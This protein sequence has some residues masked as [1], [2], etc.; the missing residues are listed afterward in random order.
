MALDSAEPG[1]SGVPRTISSDGQ[2]EAL[3]R[4]HNMFPS[5][6]EI[7]HRQRMFEL[8][9]STVERQVMNNDV[10]TRLNLSFVVVP[11]GSHGLTVWDCSS[12]MDCLAIGTISPTVFF[13]L[14]AQKIHFPESQ[15]VKI[16]RKT[17]DASG[18]MLGLQ[19]GGVCFNLQYC[20][21]TKVT[22]CWPQALE[23]PSSHPAFDVPM[24]SLLKLN[25]VR[26]LHYLQHTITHLA[27]FRLA[28]RAIKTWAK[29]RGIYSSKFG[30]LGDMH[31][32]LLLAR[33][34]KTSFHEGY[35]T[36]ASEILQAYFKHYA[37]FDWQKEMIYDPTY[38]ADTTPSYHRSYREPLVI[39][40]IHPPKVNV[41]QTATV[42]S[43]KT[44][45]EEFKRAEQLIS[46]LGATWV[47]G[48]DTD[49]KPTGYVDFL[50][51]YI[52]YIKLDANYWGGAQIKW[53]KLV[54]WLE[55]RCVYLLGDINRRFPG[56]HARI[57][58]GLFTESEEGQIEKQVE[59]RGC[60][61]I[62]LAKN[63]NISNQPFSDDSD[64]HS[65]HV[66][67][68]ALLESF[69]E[70][71]RSNEAYFD[72]HVLWADVAFVKQ[73]ELKDVRLCDSDWTNTVVSH[74]EDLDLDDGFEHDI[75]NGSIEGGGTVQDSNKSQQIDQPV[76]SA[77]V[78]AKPK[79]RPAE[80][81]ISRL[82][83]DPSFDAADYV[84]GYLDR[85]IGEKEVPVSLWKSEQTDEEFIPMHRVLYFKRRSDGQRVWDRQK[86][87]D[88]IF[89]TGDTANGL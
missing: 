10:A 53:L 12:D 37:N 3:L 32:T 89:N 65:A 64:R 69:A 14:M 74:G 6:D 45:R 7:A 81:V 84:V 76:H 55:T 73:S 59:Y 71:I 80:D 60:F 78:A 52:N 27:S 68:L 72:K 20:A 66:S 49:A 39:L 34:C 58:P 47:G 70:Q 23:L 41:A 56:I 26:D 1:L 35:A 19:A 21:A 18:T 28:Y 4:H 13:A 15:E 9:K 54:G 8:I 25:A 86:R 2:L 33:V 24:Q 38:Y 44:L 83:W 63:D 5:E 79:L 57:W 61:L 48:I 46:R 30:Y 42:P 40:S 43:V 62:G 85:F 82:R 29:D 87:I 51:S 75:D 31:I 88:L 16:F 36:S 50:N 77:N 22:E 17:N 67:L 11:V